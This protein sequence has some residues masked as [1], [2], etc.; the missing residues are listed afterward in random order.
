MRGINQRQI[1]L[2][3]IKAKFTVILIYLMKSLLIDTYC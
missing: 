2:V 3:N 1:N